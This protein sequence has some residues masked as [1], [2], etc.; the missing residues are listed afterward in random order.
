MILRRNPTKVAL[1]SRFTSVL[2]EK[3]NLFKNSKN[4]L[5]QET[6]NSNNNLKIKG[7]S[8][9]ETKLIRSFGYEIEHKQK[10]TVGLVSWCQMV[11]H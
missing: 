10:I 5:E 8:A 1:V 6:N 7:G 3:T 4:E 9:R 2:H 11:L